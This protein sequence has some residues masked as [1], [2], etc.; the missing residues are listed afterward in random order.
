MVSP[1][2]KAK[3]ERRVQR[4]RLGLQGLGECQGNL[5]HR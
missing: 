5:D 2:L 3:L 1:E 4:E